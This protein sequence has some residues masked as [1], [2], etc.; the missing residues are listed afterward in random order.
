ME[1]MPGY[2]AM[3]VIPANIQEQPMASNHQQAE[4]EVTICNRQGLHARP[5][6]RFVD[7]A[8]TFSSSIRVRKPDGQEVDGKSPME[9][10]LLEASH[11]TVLRLLAKGQDADA[12]VA[13][14]AGL[15][16]NKFGED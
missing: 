13:A 5:V 12:A 1:R 2:E 8:S 15:I 16:Q 4:C 11:G 14:L 6:M 9:M 7:L 3:G 10:M